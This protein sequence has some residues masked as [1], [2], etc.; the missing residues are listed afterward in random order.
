MGSLIYKC[1]GC[2]SLFEQHFPG[3][4]IYL[5][6]T[7]T[8]AALFLLFF[9]SFSAQFACAKIR[10]TIN[11]Q[12]HKLLMLNYLPWQ[13]SKYSK[14]RSI[15]WKAKA[16]DIWPLAKSAPIVRYY[17]GWLD[18]W[19][20]ALPSSSC[21]HIYIIVFHLA[22]MYE[23]VVMCMWTG[24]HIVIFINLRTVS[25]RS[26]TTAQSTYFSLCNFFY[27]FPS[28]WVDFDCAPPYTTFTRLLLQTASR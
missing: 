24:K 1:V 25:Q 9:L 8:I 4:S 11:E 20:F 6:A 12:Y 23:T 27:V 28:K 17:V 19:L 22:V 16:S 2:L 7:V 14:W 26:G 13:H 3:L 10:E 21:A 18:G 5:R 15:V